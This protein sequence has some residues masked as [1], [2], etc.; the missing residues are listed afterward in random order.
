MELKLLGPF[1]VNQTLLRTPVQKDTEY[2][3]CIPS[4]DS[5]PWKSCPVQRHLPNKTVPSPAVGEA[6]QK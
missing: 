5:R 3:N 1:N 6:S 2:W 4:L